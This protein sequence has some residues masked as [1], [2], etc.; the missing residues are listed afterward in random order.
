MKILTKRKQYVANNSESRLLRISLVLLA[1]LSFCFSFRA[2]ICPAAPPHDGT[3]RER[4]VVQGEGE[5]KI[6]NR[7]LTGARK[8]AL[9]RAMKSAFES[10]MTQVA[11]EPLSL[12]EQHALLRDLAPRMNSFLVQYRFEEMPSEE[13]I[14]VTV[15]AAFSRSSFLEEFRKRGLFAVDGQDGREPETLF[16]TIRG[17]MDV[18]TYLEVTQE[19]ERRVEPVLSLVPHE[20][21]GNELTLKVEYRGDMEELELSARKSL[22]EI[23]A[24]RFGAREEMDISVS[25]VPPGET[26]EESVP[27]TG[28]APGEVEAEGVPSSPSP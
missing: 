5:A 17:I 1:A 11:P 25:R 26:V 6:R 7:D 19:L 12:P 18:R 21:Y 20:I 22:Q 2:T 13:V 28:D 23:F 8:K 15:E 24:G 16:L 4:I 3:E 10:A 9:N 27:G 14:F